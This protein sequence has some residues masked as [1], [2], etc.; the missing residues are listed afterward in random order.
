MVYQPIHHRNLWSIAYRYFTSTCITM[1]TSL[2]QNALID[3]HQ[4]VSVLSGNL[5]GNNQDYEVN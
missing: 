1:T 2:E 4:V 5:M 3:F